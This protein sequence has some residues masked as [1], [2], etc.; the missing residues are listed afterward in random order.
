MKDRETVLEVG[1]LVL[2]LS[3]LGGAVL[4][5]VGRGVGAAGQTRRR[6]LPPPSAGTVSHDLH[7]NVSGAAAR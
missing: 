1:L 7:Q 5:L 6:S 2:L 3:L 4:A